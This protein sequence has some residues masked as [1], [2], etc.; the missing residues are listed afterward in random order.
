MQA[1]PQLPLTWLFLPHL[2]TARDMESLPAALE[3]PCCVASVAS[4]RPSRE[5]QSRDRTIPRASNS[6]T[7]EASPGPGEIA[8]RE[9]VAAKPKFL[10]HGLS[11]L[12]FIPG[13]KSAEGT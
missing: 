12:F 1:W 13:H 8:G 2:G 7:A 3:R 6:E 9:T 5:P 11:Q 4:I 10:A